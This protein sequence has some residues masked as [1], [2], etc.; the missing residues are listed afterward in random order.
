MILPLITVTINA[1]HAPWTNHAP[2]TADNK[3]LSQHVPAANRF[4]TNELWAVFD[5]HDANRDRFDLK[6]SLSLKPC[7]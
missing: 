3:V 4:T 2:S 1:D 5:K 6:M 7:Q